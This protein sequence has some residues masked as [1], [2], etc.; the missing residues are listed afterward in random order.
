[1]SPVHLQVQ[2]DLAA[3]EAELGRR[4]DE[5]SGLREAQRAAHS[6]I[7]LYLSDLQ[8]WSTPAALLLSHRAPLDGGC[9]AAQ[10]QGCEQWWNQYSAHWAGKLQ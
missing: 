2:R 5:I 1:M 6:Q 3:K 7:N 8:V 9:C 10:G 4:G